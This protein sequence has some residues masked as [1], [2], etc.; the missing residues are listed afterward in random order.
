LAKEDLQNETE[1]LCEQFI[2]NSILT[3]QSSENVQFIDL[4]QTELE[5]FTTFRQKLIIEKQKSD[6]L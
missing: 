1:K 5:N 4:N 3:L 2:R 6:A